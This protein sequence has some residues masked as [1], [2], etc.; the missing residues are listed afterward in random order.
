MARRFRAAARRS[1]A[2]AGSSGG[3]CASSYTVSREIGVLSRRAAFLP[4]VT[5]RSLPPLPQPLQPRAGR[6]AV[7]G[8]VMSD[9]PL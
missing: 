6:G 2:D 1:A 3:W 5:A 9:E 7:F 4:G 8:P